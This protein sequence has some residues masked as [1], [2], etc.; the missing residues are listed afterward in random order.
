MRYQRS[1][2]S[3]QEHDNVEIIC[4]DNKI[5]VLL[6]MCRRVLYWYPLYVNHPGGSRPEIIIQHVCYW[7]LLV[8]QVDLSVKICNKYSTVQ[9][10]KDS[11]WTSATQYFWTIK[12]V[13]LGAYQPGRYILRF[14]NTT[15]ARWLDHQEIFEPHM[16]D[17]DWSCYRLVGNC[18]SPLFLTSMR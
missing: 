9:K 18:Q 14:N 13:E 1:S 11:L 5:Y 3:Q 4:F 16:H 15:A 10:E 6:T 12:N 7:K 17:N 2:Y 8:M